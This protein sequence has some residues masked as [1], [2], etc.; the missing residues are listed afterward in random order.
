LVVL[1]FVFEWWVKD[2]DVFWRLPNQ[3]SSWRKEML[4]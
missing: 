2:P 4:R 3:A 1:V